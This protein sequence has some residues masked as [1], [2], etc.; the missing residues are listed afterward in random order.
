[1]CVIKVYCPVVNLRLDIGGVVVLMGI[2]MPAL[3]RAREQGKRAMCMNH[4]RQLQISWSMYADENNDSIVNGNAGEVGDGYSVKDCWVE[5][6]YGAETYEEKKAAI[7]QG[8]LFPYVNNVKAYHCPTGFISKTEL[9]MFCIVDSMNV[10]E[11]RESGFTGAKM[12]KKRS[13]IKRPSDRLVFIDD[14][15]TGWQYHGWVDCIRHSV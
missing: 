5:Q 8:A 6:D 13:R 1:M 14:G 7:E 4:L 9:R 10:K 3:S 15:G 11:W 12:Y 2:L